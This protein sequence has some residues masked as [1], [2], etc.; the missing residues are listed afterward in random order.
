MSN[1]KKVY[2][3]DIY[4]EDGGLHI[5]AY[6]PALGSDPEEHWKDNSSFIYDT[7]GCGNI[8]NAVETVKEF[9]KTEYA[10]ADYLEYTTYP[11]S[12]VFK[13]TPVLSEERQWLH[14]LLLGKYD[15]IGVTLNNS[16]K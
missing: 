6:N 3:I 2:A 9:L 13:D 5:H 11:G 1:R 4:E 8:I 14:K 12:T 10:V 7:C 15:D 16:V